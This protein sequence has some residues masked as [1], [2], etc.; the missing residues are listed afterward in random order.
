MFKMLRRLLGRSRFEDGS[1]I[2][3][4]SRESLAYQRASTV[5]N[6]EFLRDGRVSIL[7]ADRD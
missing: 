3:P 7:S 2:R 6:I 1:V 5:V 4:T